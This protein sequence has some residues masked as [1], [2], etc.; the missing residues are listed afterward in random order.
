MDRTKIVVGVDGSASSGAA[1]RFAA[2]EADRRGIPLHVLAGYEYN[3]QAARFGGAEE[4]ERM[5]RDRFVGFVN[6]AVRE[7]ESIHPALPVT[8]AA[9]PGDPVRTL[10]DASDTAT[11]LVVGNRGHGGFANL[12]LGSVGQRVAVHARGPVVVVR[13]SGGRASRPVIV[14]VDRS[15]GAAEALGLGFEEAALRG[16]TLIAVH[17]FHTPT[18]PWTVGVPPLPYDTTAVERAAREDLDAALVPWREKYP[19]VAVESLVGAGSAARIL[20]DVSSNAGLIVVGSHGH[21]ALVGTLLG[22]VGLQL[23]HHAECPVLIAHRA[24]DRVAA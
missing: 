24:A 16:S 7:A 9:V 14:G 21:G 15:D 13:G 5:V 22:S 23:L 17:A 19:T 10:L 2:A 12:M 18:P 4:L 20:V 8:G 6:D 11:M 3:W 1:L